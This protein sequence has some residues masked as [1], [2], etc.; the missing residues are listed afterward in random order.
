MLSPQENIGAP[1]F[2]QAYSEF[3][4]RS[5]VE[6]SPR[7]AGII[8][9]LSSAEPQ[10]QREGLRQLIDFPKKF[11]DKS[12]F[13]VGKIDT[14]QLG[15]IYGREELIAAVRGERLIL[16]SDLGDDHGSVVLKGNIILRQLLESL[17]VIAAADSQNGAVLVLSPVRDISPYVHHGETLHNRSFYEDINPEA[18]LTQGSLIW[19]GIGSAGGENN[20]GLP[21]NIDRR[22]RDNW[23]YGGATRE[24]V[25]VTADSAQKL[26]Q[27]SARLRQK[28]PEI[29]D[30]LFFVPVVSIQ[31]LYLPVKAM[32]D[33]DYLRGYVNNR[34]KEVQ[35][36]VFCCRYGRLLN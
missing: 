28:F 9:L 18:L 3:V 33:F 23:I 21:F 15:G 17:G 36:G 16:L 27:A 34:G 14:R 30:D 8:S 22:S 1:A 26:R 12:I 2:R 35:P 13:T 24:E 5:G 20:I 19:K 4:L 11:F 31:P 7:L 25:D 6:V 10:S 32:G 29:P